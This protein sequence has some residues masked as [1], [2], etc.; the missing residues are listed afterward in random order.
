MA[1]AMTPEEIQEIFE[2]YEY[3]VNKLGRATAETTEAYNDAKIGIRNYTRELKASALGFRTAVKDL[4]GSMME[5][6]KGASQYGDALSKGADYLGHWMSSKGPWGMAGSMLIKGAVAYTNAVTKQADN[7]FKSYQE[8]S[9]AG[10]AGA[11]GIT[12][13]YSTMQKF[14]YGIAELGNLGALIQENASNL[15]LLGGT[16]NQ[17]AQ[18]FG[19]LSRSIRDSEIGAQFERMGISVDNMNKGIVGYLRIQN[20]TGQQQKKTQEEL[21]QG[22]EAYIREQDRLTKLTGMNANEQQQA[23]EAA[24]REERFGAGIRQLERRAREEGNESLAR[25]AKKREEINQLLVKETPELAKGFRDITTGYLNSPEAQ[26]FLRTMPTASKAIQEGA[27]QATIM[28]AMQKDAQRTLRQNEELYKAGVGEKLYG[29]GAELAILAGQMTLEER[30]K[31]V[32]KEQQVADAATDSM[33]GTVRAQRDT[34]DSLQD[35]VQIG[36]RPTTAAMEGLAKIIKQVAGVPAKAATGITGGAGGTRARE[37]AVPPTGAA[38][39]APE[40]VGGGKSYI[41]RLI[42]VESGG[43][44]I[45][46]QSGPGGA[47]TSSAFGLT[48]FTKG[49]FETLVKKAGRDNPLF[50]KTFEDY[51]KD[52]DLQLEATR[53]LTDQNR[54]YLQKMGV[55]TTDS[56]LYLAHF[57][58]PGGAVKALSQPDF[59]PLMNAVSM[60][61]IKANPHLAKMNTVGDLKKWADQKFGSG[62]R[63]GGI[64][65]GPESGYQAMLHGTEA[66]VPL[67]DGKTIPVEIPGFANSLND[68]SGLLSQQLSKLDDLIRVMQT[69]V[70]VSNKILQRTS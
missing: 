46:N 51:K 67:P 59:S 61:Q 69:Q 6:S 70:S 52:T 43:R 58:G 57:L 4:T 5:S 11:G 28:A 30:E 10:L 18:R 41:E 2:R 55:S 26:M 35:L 3:E 44:N 33:V 53:Q 48:Q 34:R 14:G 22:A 56:A 8:V 50:G 66:V 40:R 54:Q 39:T 37:I 62:Y 17:G 45:A 13:L 23:R 42:Q 1:Q 27:D 9:R 47:P 36:I 64:A 32:G 24:L 12:E 65:T 25:E 15:A 20:L 21:R 7:L 29:R 49:T 31:Q 68:Q 63:D 38:P 60:D 19:D 16:V